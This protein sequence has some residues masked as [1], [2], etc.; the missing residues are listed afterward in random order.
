MR[1]LWVLEVGGS[2]PPFSTNMTKSSAT[3]ARQIHLGIDENGL[4]PRLDPIVVTAIMAETNAHG[5]ALIDQPAAGELKKRLGDSKG[6]VAHGNIGLAEAW[7]RVL[8]ER[9]VTRRASAQTTAELIEALSLDAPEVLR[10]PCPPSAER[11]C[12]RHPE[13]QE[14]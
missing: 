8:V 4:G 7:A 5:R 13:R 9:G 12:W 2:N 1:E 3:N 6:L 14:D 10:A 11:Q